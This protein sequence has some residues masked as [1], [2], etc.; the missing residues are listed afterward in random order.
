MAN[1]ATDNN[2]WLWSKLGCVEREVQSQTSGGRGDVAKNTAISSKILSG[3]IVSSD[4]NDSLWQL[5]ICTSVGTG[6]TADFAAF[7]VVRPSPSSATAVLGVTVSM[8]SRSSNWGQ[9]RPQ[10]D[11]KYQG[12][13]PIGQPRLTIKS[14]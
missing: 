11:P 1:L 13:P 4:E 14:R 5:Q 7:A 3:F 8:G 9:L 2:R 10:K 12:F 6:G